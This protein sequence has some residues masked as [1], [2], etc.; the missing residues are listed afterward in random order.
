M[1]QTNV[2]EVAMREKTELINKLSAAITESVMD[3]S[4]HRYTFLDFLL[5]KLPRSLTL[6][7]NVLHIRMNIVRMHMF[8]YVHRD[9][10][11]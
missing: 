10:Y 2:A 4:M 8:I 11:V 3:L 1:R 5:N 9:M 6:R 7:S